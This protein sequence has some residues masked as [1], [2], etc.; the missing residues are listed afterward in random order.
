DVG[1]RMTLQALADSR[2]ESL[3]TEYSIF[4]SFTTSS[5]V[6]WPRDEPQTPRSTTGLSLYLWNISL[7]WGMEARQGPHQV[8]QKSTMTTLPFMSSF[9]ISP[10]FQ[11]VSLSS[12]MGLP[13]MASCCSR[14]SG[15]PKNHSEGNSFFFFSSAAAKR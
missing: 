11:S 9:L 7:L 13:S 3:A 12:G 14:C 5:S 4:L 1:H 2:V 8:A 10:F 6:S 15:L